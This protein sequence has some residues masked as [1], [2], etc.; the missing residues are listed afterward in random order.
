MCVYGF[1][2]CFSLFLVLYFAFTTVE[3]NLT[4]DNWTTVFADGQN[5]KVIGTTF[6]I[7]GIT[8]VICL[9]IAYPIAYLL[10]NKKYN[11]NVIL[12]YI[13]LLPMW[14]NFVIC[15]IGLKTL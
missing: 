6:I 15:T 7:A 11:K 14:I 8:T 2:C 5:W 4:F 12:V 13:F 10:A 1:V 3:G 9:L